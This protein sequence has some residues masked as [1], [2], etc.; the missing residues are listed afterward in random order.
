M[1]SLF[2]TLQAFQLR[3]STEGENKNAFLYVFKKA[4]SGTVIFMNFYSNRCF[5]ID[6]SFCIQL[7]LYGKQLG[8]YI[9][10]TY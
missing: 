9:I 4:V 6:Y 8:L 3:D 5:N 1:F 2:N 10:Y 7:E